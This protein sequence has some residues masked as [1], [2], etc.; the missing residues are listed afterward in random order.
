[1]DKLW[2]PWRINYIRQNK[3]KG[4]VFCRI[5]D[6]K[7]DK[8]NFI[9]FRSQFC[10]VVFNTYP[11]NNGHVMVISRRHTDSL[12]KLSDEEVLDMNKSL[13]KIKSV[14]KKVLK[15]QGFNIGMNIG[16]TAGAGIEKHLHI[17]LV[18]RWTGDTNFM[19]VISDSK[20]ISQGLNELFL[21]VKKCLQEK[22]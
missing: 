3:Q 2:A 8:N 18:P 19:P 21:Q 17:H 5:R 11:Y 20:I 12:E 13:I 15:P 14:L 4:C 7:K 9:I 6:E 1:M 10:F 16:K 22:K